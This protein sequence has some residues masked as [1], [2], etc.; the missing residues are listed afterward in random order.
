MNKCELEVD[1]VAADIL[2]RQDVTGQ[3]C[4]SHPFSLI[5]NDSVGFGECELGWTK[6]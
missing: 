2:N 3:R 1:K 5:V 6:W 4:H